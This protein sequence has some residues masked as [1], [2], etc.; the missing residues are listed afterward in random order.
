MTNA[1]LVPFATYDNAKAWQ[2]TSE[3]FIYCIDLIG[4]SANHRDA[5]KLVNA[6]EDAFEAL[7]SYDN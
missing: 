1:K 4:I 6:L 2:A 3:K 7:L 5:D